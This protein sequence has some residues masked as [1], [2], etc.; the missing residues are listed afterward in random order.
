MNLLSKGTNVSDLFEIEEM[1][2]AKGGT[3]VIYLATQKK[4]GK[5]LVVLKMAKTDDG[6][7]NKEAVLLKREA[8]LLSTLRHPGV[9]QIYPIN[10]QLSYIERAINLVNKPYYIV[11]EPLTG[12]TV[13]QNIDTIMSFDLNWRF[14]LFYQILL[15]VNFLHS[16]NYGHRDLKPQNIVFRTP[17]SRD[18]IPQPVCIDF[19]IAERLGEVPF[20]FVDGARSMPYASIERIMRSQYPPERI[21]RSTPMM[22]DIWSLGTILYYILTTQLPYQG[23]TVEEF[24]TSVRNSGPR[25][26]CSINPELRNYGRLND[27]VQRML[28]NNPEERPT[29]DKILKA[30]DLVIAPPPRVRVDIKK[31]KKFI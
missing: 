2:S 10:D 16:Q 23:R 30:I 14:E 5:L 31:M 7:L 24:T 3:A 27:L 26:I 29:I 9:V 19:G 6:S 22:E 15:S 21:P 11:M 20:D 28:S 8:D 13:T 4:P 17:I 12:G 1:I 18:Q 25:D